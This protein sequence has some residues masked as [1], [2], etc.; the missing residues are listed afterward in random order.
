VSQ[1]DPGAEGRAS[2]RA[3]GPFEDY[4]VGGEHAESMEWL[5]RVDRAERPETVGYVFH[6]DTE[7]IHEAVLDPEGGEWVP[8]LEDGRELAAEETL[9]DAVAEIGDRLGW[10]GLSAFADE[11][12]T[13]DGD[14]GEREGEGED[15]SESDG[16]RD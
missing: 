14:G 10:A 5:G 9:G 16:G 1:N 12:L 8:D 4:Q 13:E 7:M 2:G 11:H 6:R 3:G 15:E